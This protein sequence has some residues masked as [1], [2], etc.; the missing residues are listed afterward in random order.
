MTTLFKQLKMNQFSY[1]LFQKRAGF[2][3]S[4]ADIATLPALRHSMG[5]F[6]YSLLLRAGLKTNTKL[7]QPIFDLYL[8][9]T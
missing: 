8:K 6:I 4:I 7:L 9:T 3:L 2:R 1:K 5:V